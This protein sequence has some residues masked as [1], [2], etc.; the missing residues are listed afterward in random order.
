M[1]CETIRTVVVRVINKKTIV[2]NNL[3]SRFDAE[4]TILKKMK[5]KNVVQMLEMWQ[6]EI[7]VPIVME[8]VSG[9]NLLDVMI[10]GELR[11]EQARFYFQQLMEGVGFLHKLGI[12]HRNLELE[13][14][15]LIPCTMC[16][17]CA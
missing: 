4:C 17:Y 7:E 12:C 10:A 11:Q 3:R 6:T 15:F 8:Y 1:D 2:E 5:H 9:T 13:V 14:Y 16:F